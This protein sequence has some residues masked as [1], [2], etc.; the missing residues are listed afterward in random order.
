MCVCVFVF[1]FKYFKQIIPLIYV[2]C[3]FKVLLANNICA[4]LNKFPPKNHKK[5]MNRKIGG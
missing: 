3:R 1:G 2:D 4:N 5:E